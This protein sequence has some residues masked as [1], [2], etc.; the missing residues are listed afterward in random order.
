MISR[1]FLFAAIAC[2]AA[3]QHKPASS[4]SARDLK[5]EARFHQAGLIL[6]PDLQHS[7]AWEKLI[8]VNMGVPADKIEVQ[9]GPGFTTVT[10]KDLKNRADAESVAQELRAIADKQPDKFGVTK[11]EVRLSNLP[12]TINPFTLPTEMSP[13]VPTPGSD[14]PT[15]SLPPL[16][17]DGR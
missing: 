10:I 15:L 3:C 11:V 13:S 12:A 1:F 17:I 2:L 6:I 14:L 7:S 8:H 16:R 4:T 9:A 5:E